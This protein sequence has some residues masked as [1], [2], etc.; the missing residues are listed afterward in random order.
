MQV[1][2]PDGRTLVFMQDGTQ[3]M[4]DMEI[5]GPGWVTF[6]YLGGEQKL[7][8]DADEWPAFLAMVLEIDAARTAA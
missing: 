4:A 6:D 1:M 2:R 8:V 5:A 7:L 3:F